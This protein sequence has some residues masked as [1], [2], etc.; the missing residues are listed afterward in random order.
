MLVLV[1][2]ADGLG[3]RRVDPQVYSAARGRIYVGVDVLSESHGKL[4]LADFLEFVPRCG[5]Q[6][7]DG[8][9]APQMIA[10]ARAAT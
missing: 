9:Q 7:T 3:W 4:E 10:T 1:G 8:D 5:I 2:R 6:L